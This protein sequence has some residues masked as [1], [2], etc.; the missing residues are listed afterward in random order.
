M[1]VLGGKI[2]GGRCRAFLM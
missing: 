2:E 1:C